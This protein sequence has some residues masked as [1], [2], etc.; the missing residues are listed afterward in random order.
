MFRKVLLPLCLPGLVVGFLT[1]FN[2][3]MGAF[4]SAAVLG[5]GAVLTL[6]ASADEPLELP[7]WPG[8]LPRLPMP[9]RWK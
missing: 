2:T 8:V 3:S 9:R 5:K 6:P 1:I 4:T 7:E